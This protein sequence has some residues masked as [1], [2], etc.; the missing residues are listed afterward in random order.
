MTAPE[1]P[2]ASDALARATE[3]LW[4][5]QRPGPEGDGSFDGAN[6]G[7]P[8]YTGLALVVEGWLG[9]LGDA[10]AGEATRWLLA[11][12]RAD[13]GFSG[14]PLRGPATVDATWATLAGLR[15]AGQPG[16]ER[17]V[18]AAES[19]LDGRPPGPFV[20]PILSVTNPAW[21]PRVPL[22]WMAF[23]PAR[24]LAWSRLH[25]WIVLAFASMAGIGHGLAKTGRRGLLD[26]RAEDATIALLLQT[27]NPCGSWAGAALFT[28]QAVVALKL[29][30]F[31]DPA[32]GDRGP[33]PVRRAL[34]WL[35]RW[36]RRDD[37]GLE[38]MPFTADAW[39]TARA[40]RALLVAGASPTDHRV[41]RAASW[42][43]ARQARHASPDEWQNV[44]PGHSRHGGW[45]YESTNVVSPD[46]DTTAA[47][48][49]ALAPLVGQPGAVD[50]RPA[51]DAATDWLLGMQNADG[52]WPGFRRGVGHKP[53][54]PMFQ[55][56]IG[57]P[58]DPLAAMRLFANPPPELTDPSTEDLTGRVLVGLGTRD[59]DQRVRA[60]AVEF[61]ERQQ[62]GSRWFGRWD[63]N[64]QAG[65]AYVLAGLEAGG[66][67]TV[68]PCYRRAVEWLEMRQNADGGW[69]EGIDTYRVPDAGPA[70]SRADLTG[71]AL[72]AL[73]A[74]G[75]ADTEPARRAVAFLCRTQSPGGDWAGNGAPTPL[76]IVNPP[77]EFYSNPVASLA[78]PVEAL[79]AWLEA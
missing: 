7:G 31:D 46:T 37:T 64:Y 29:L 5:R 69:G 60:R 10:D 2:A 20:A 11:Q 59:V 9:V 58:T 50:V 34:D 41:T 38:V 63:V 24:R 51:L 48:V 52:G 49:A 26:R 32:P 28:L 6:H 56:P 68:E 3:A 25:P 27:Q 44:A 22:A 15:A 74:A 12:Q 76:Y 14:T 40:L 71:T 66:M 65:T 45:A 1:R 19:F 54:G 4:R 16:V 23:P 39:N 79:G 53:P 33:R 21:A 36:K 62:W 30:G 57:I 35:G 47:V 18:R 72:L 78:A 13:G 61:L 8:M 67:S 70:E 55:R 75:R 43:V 77:D 42:L 17:A 73:V